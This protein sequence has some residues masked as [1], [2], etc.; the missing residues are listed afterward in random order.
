M[1]RILDM[2]ESR[3]FRTQKNLRKPFE[4]LNQ[5]SEKRGEYGHLGYDIIDCLLY[6]NLF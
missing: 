1:K 5:N 2:L 3:F 6:A 4:G